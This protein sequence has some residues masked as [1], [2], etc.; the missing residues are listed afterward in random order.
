VA[1]REV[2]LHPFDLNPIAQRVYARRQRFRPLLFSRFLCVIYA[3]LALCNT[4]Q[5]YSPP[6][7][8]AE[9]ES[10]RQSVGKSGISGNF[11]I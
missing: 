8:T 4:Q 9:K 6:S 1:G 2:F 10:F 7:V 5:G 11:A 3:N